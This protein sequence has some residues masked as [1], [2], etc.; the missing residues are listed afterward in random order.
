M[1]C[2]HS[3]YTVLRR[4]EGD[5]QHTP[6][7]HRTSTTSRFNS[8]KILCPYNVSALQWHM[9]VC[10][11]VFKNTRILPFGA[12]FSAVL[13]LVF[14]LCWLSSELIVPLSFSL[15]S[16][17]PLLLTLLLSLLLLLVVLS[18]F[19]FSYHRRP[20]RRVVVEN[21]A[22]IGKEEQQWPSIDHRPYTWI[23]KKKN[24]Y[25]NNSILHAMR[26]H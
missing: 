10:V 14:Q 24:K 16:S 6:R 13:A 26:E 7:T 18:M 1:F 8:D 4:N 11:C 17:L 3:I 21:P 23:M 15:A 19:L 20:E 9:C 25:Y 5:T 2:Y 12:I 22:T